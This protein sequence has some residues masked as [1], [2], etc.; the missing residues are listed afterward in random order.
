MTG[1]EVSEP[2]ERTNSDRSSCTYWFPES[3]YG[4]RPAGDAMLP[5]RVV[6]LV[7]HQIIYPLG[8]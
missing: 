3:L 5:R 2:M 6:G 4:I 1:L 7:G 8:T